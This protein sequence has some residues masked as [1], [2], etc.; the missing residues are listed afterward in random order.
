VWLVVAVMGA[1]AA[2]SGRSAASPRPTTT[3]ARTVT[4]TTAAAACSP[5]RPAPPNGPQT[6]AFGGEHRTYLLAV[7]L[8]YDGRSAYPLV[9]NFHGFAS[10][11][12]AQEANTSMGAKGADRGYIVVTPSSDPP[13]WNEFSAPNRPDDYAFVHAVVADLEARL[14]IDAQRVYAAGHS[15]GSAF[16]GFLVCKAPYVF[17]AVAMVSATVP[18][19]CPDGVAP[20]L[21]AIAGTADPQVPYAGGKVAGS[22]IAIPAATDTIQAS[23]TRYH[24]N[25]VPA[26]DQPLAGVDRVRYSACVDGADVVLDTIV[27][28][29]HHWPGG[30]VAATD[31]ADSDAGRYF[32]ATAAI[33][34]FFDHHHRPPHE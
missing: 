15:N 11:G 21:L 24:C 12:P 18:S 14:C 4:S 30:A 1:L 29:T 33:L 7:P 3:L 23:V 26:G 9:F 20:A 25:P 10:N 13:E 6:L 19:I 16:A 28:G 32:D 8:H 22:T 27:G 2:C 5:T 17:A 31:P 34:D